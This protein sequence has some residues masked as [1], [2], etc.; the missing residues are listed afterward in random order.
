V[1]YNASPPEITIRQGDLNDVRVFECTGVEDLTWASSAAAFVWTDDIAEVPLVATITDAA[2]RLVS[3]NF[4]AAA[5]WSS[6]AQPGTY[7]LRIKATGASASKT[8]PERREDYIRVT[9][10]A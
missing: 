5:G 7:L 8:F 3:V 6:T 9:L 2:A 1:S 10:T 4:G